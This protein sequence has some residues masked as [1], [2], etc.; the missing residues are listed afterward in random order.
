MYTIVTEYKIFIDTISN[1]IYLLLDFCIVSKKIIY[2]YIKMLLKYSCLY[3]IHISVRPVFFFS[4]FK[5]LIS[6]WMKD[7]CFREFCC[8]LSNLNMN[9]PQ[10]YI[11]PLPFE[12]ASHLPP[13]L[14]P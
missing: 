2:E 14:T 7:N 3:Q 9:Q 12:T 4:F 6:F 10:V 11:D 8:F 5:K 1:C 13:H